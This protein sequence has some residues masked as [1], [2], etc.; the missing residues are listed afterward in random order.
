MKL[1]P[2]TF[3]F[4]VMLTIRL[5]WYNRNEEEVT[6]NLSRLLPVTSMSPEDVHPS[7]VTAIGHAK[8]NVSFAMF[9]QLNSKFSFT[10]DIKQ[11]KQG[12]KLFIEGFQVCIQLQFFH[13]ALVEFLARRP[14]T[15]LP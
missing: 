3:K 6:K 10:I 2:G 14:N 15:S 5:V 8:L 12:A 9:G 11:I 7:E 4:G 1:R 13:H